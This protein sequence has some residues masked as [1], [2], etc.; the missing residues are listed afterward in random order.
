[1]T[2]K[3]CH[4][5]SPLTARAKGG[6]RKR[7]LR[8][9]ILAHPHMRWV[10]GEG[11]VSFWDD[12]WL[13][14]APLRE[15]SMDDRGGPLVRVADFIMEGKWNE[16]KL[17]LIQAQAGLTPQVVRKILDTPI[18]PDG[19]DV[20]RWRLS[21]NGE[22]SLATTWET[23]RTQRPTIQGLD[24][25]W[26]A[27]LTSSMA[28]FIWRHIS[29]RIPV[30]TKLQWRKMEM[31]SKCQCC[32]HRPGIESLQ[33]LFIQGSGASA[34]WREFD[35][36]FG[37][38][39]PPLRI[40]DTIPDRLKVWA[41]RV[42]RQ[43]RKHLGRAMP[44][45]ILWFLWAERNRSRHQSVRFKPFNVVWQVQTFIRNGMTNGT[46]KPKHWKGVLLKVNI[47]NQAEPRRSR[48]LAMAI[49]W[50]PPEQPWIK[51]NTDGAYCEDTD[52]A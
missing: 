26:K 22:F 24:D 21:R 2:A 33:H 31:A 39:S 38:S 15:L 6:S 1:M 52:K 11:N 7:L 20:P 16:A 12:L 45:I 46:Y 3:Y 41:Q 34:V 35:S 13:G 51:L 14:D 42:R 4:K 30:D 9:R 43:G 23:T 25:I 50:N 17:R 5:A 47:P 10:V 19:P 48:P 28:I 40:N 36:W 27:G 29:N 49:K 8:A 44:Y 37:G 32:P 18:I